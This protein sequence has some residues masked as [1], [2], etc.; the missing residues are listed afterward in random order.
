MEY[1]THLLMSE[2]FIPHGH[3]YLWKTELVGL[4]LI[5]DLTTAIAYFSIPLT[6]FHFVEKRED[7]PF[8]W[9]FNLFGAFIIL[10]G[11]TH[12]LEVWT[13]WHPV[14]WLSG[15]VKAATGIV[16]AYTALVLVKLIPQALLLP[17]PAQLAATNQ[18]LE[19]QI[20][21]REL[22]EAQLQQVND[23]LEARVAARTLEL[24]AAML[25]TRNLAERMTLATDAA[26]MGVFDWNLV[27]KKLVWNDYHAKMLGY[28]FSAAE[29]SYADW[30][31]RVHPEDLPAVKAALELAVT[32]HSDFVTQYRVIWPDGSI[33]WLDAFGRSYYNNDRADRMLGI[34]CEVT[35]RKQTELSLQEQTLKLAKTTALLERRNQELDQFAYIVSHDLKAPLR[36]IANLS[37]WIEESLAEKIGAET[38]NYLN[39]MRSRVVRMTSL[40]DGLLDYARVGQTEV[41]LTTF[42]IEDLLAE[43]I[44]SLN[45]S[46]SFRIDLPTNLPPIVTNRLLLS[47]VFANLIG[48]AYKHHDR[49]D[50]HIQITAQLQADLWKFAVTD[51]GP[52]IPAADFDRVFDIFQTLVERDRQENTGI[53]LSI[54]KKL[55]HSHGGEIAIESELGRGTTFRFTWSQADSVL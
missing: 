33:H 39:L 51:D 12:L 8:N 48:N 46:D 37:E 28:T 27:T 35:E 32:T 7:L 22:V 18:A 15:T 13:L 42:A 17:S 40:I 53:G 16:S 49:T 11:T 47:Q 26:R 14:Y 6:L 43:I 50:G 38:Q 20:R 2:F 55:V 21:A 5:S 24:E 29:Y 9:I 54:V 31:R 10:C 36:G 45:I 4:H 52:G 34:I 25:L 44:D 23:E 3:C 30:E 19:Q 41:S 1:F